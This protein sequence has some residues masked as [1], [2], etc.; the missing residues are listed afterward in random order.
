L[1]RDLSIVYLMALT[2]VC[3]VILG[4]MWEAVVAVTRK[5]VWSEARMPT[6][7]LVV[8]SDRRTEALDFVGAERRR[9]SQ[10]LL[11]AH[12]AAIRAMS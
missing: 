10:M 12:K 2:A 1:E 5:P 8:S 4:V 3:V 6:L 9:E 11:S 7:R